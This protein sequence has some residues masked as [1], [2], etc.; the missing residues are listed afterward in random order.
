MALQEIVR[1][2]RLGPELLAV[3][4]GEGMAARRSDWRTM[5]SI[6]EQRRADGFHAEQ[7][8]RDYLMAHVGL[9]VVLGRLVAASPALL[10]FQ[11]EDGVKPSLLAEWGTDAE[12]LDLC[13]N[14]SHTQG[15]V[16]IA[17]AQGHEIG[18]DVEWQRPMEDLEGMARTVMSDTEAAHWQKLAQELRCR[19]FYRLW[20][21][22]ESYL[23]A[24]GL[25]LFRDLH[26]VTVPVTP[27]S[28]DEPAAVIDRNGD[29]VWSVRDLPI[30][31]GFSASLCWQG[32]STM[33]L[34]VEDLAL[35]DLP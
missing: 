27:A 25:G 12:R 18:V 16:L 29:G 9:R 10:H 15:A 20:T 8:R 32:A 4:A 23:K 22:K 30:W 6:A 13:F 1:V 17:V 35:D 24:I 21:R 19:A 26:E 31:E 34:V 3:A 14:L 5:L 28:L 2:W 7:H 11:T 33:G